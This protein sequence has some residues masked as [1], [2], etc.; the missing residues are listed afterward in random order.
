MVAVVDGEAELSRCREWRW[1]M[2]GAVAA[3]VGEEGSREMKMVSAA[4]CGQ[5][6]AMLRHSL[7]RLGH[8]RRG[9]GDVWHPL[10]TPRRLGSE[11]VGH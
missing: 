7:A 1:Q 11:P 9:T 5:V 2:L 8:T 3:M 6:R 4:E 10:A